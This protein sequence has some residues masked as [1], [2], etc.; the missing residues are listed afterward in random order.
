[1][2]RLSERQ[3]QRTHPWITFQLDLG[4]LSHKTWLLLG[5]AESKCQHVAGVPLR[6]AVAEKLHGIYLTKGIHG[7]TAIEG[8]TL[9]ADEVHKRITEGLDLPPSRDYLGKEVD[10]I[11]KAFN[12]IVNDVT[13]R[14]PLHLTPERIARFNAQVLE[15]LELEE[16]VVPGKVRTHPVAVLNYRGA[17][18]EDCELL[19]HRMCEWLN[20]MAVDDPA[21]TFSV[22]ALKAIL[23]HLYIAWIHPFGDGN[24]RTARLIEFQLLVQAGVP[25]PSAHLP[26]DFYSKTREVYYRELAKTS[27]EPYQ[28]ERFIHY[29]MQGFVDELREQLED[30][31]REQLRVAW[32]NYV[33]DVFRDRDT[34]AKRRQKYIVLDLTERDEPIAASKLPALSPRVATGYAG[35]DKKAITRDVNQLLDRQ[36]VRRERRGLVANIDIMRAFLPVRAA[37]EDDDIATYVNL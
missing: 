11:L 12:E 8:N 32:E 7:T 23:A 35:K 27:R 16:G 2:N 30:I 28:I 24:G 9:S 31:R 29:A 17:P 21:M 19:L 14:R 5:E 37:L 33:H 13:A 34:P 10:N 36:L 25:I 1:M 26:S 3:Y 22:A 18:P 20:D 4:R 15:G 6:P